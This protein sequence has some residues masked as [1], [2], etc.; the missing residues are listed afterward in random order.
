M[1]STKDDAN[2]TTVDAPLPGPAQASESEIVPRA[3]LEHGV[4]LAD[5]YRIVRLLGQGGMGSVYEAIDEARSGLRVAVKLLVVHQP[6]ALYRL[7]NEFRALAETVHPNLVGLHGLAA[8]ARGWFLVMDLVDA[9]SDFRSYVRSGENGSLDEPRLRSALVQLVRGVAAI[10]AARKLHRDLKPSNVL[11]THDGR[12]VIAD[13]GLVGDQDPEA[14]GRSWEGWFAGTPAYAAPEQVQGVAVGPAADVY[15]VGVLLFEALTGRLPIEGASIEQLCQR[16]LH[17]AAPD[18]RSLAAG[19]PADLCTLCTALLQRDPALRPDAR[20]LLV[21]LDQPPPTAVFTSLPFVG[22]ERELALLRQAVSQVRDRSPALA[23]VSGASGIGKTALVA[24]FL[25]LMRREPGTVVFSGRCHA[26]EQV[27]YNAFDRLVDVLGLYLSALSPVEAA[28][29]MPRDVALLARLF[30]TLARVPA[31]LSM[32]SG[33][34]RELDEAFLRTR[35]FAALK[36]LL[37]RIADRNLLIMCFDDLQWC[38]DDSAELLRELLRGLEAPACLFVCASRASEPNESGVVAMVRANSAWSCVELRLEPLGAA[39]STEL[40]RAMLG[41]GHASDTD[42]KLVIEE[43]AGS[44]F[45]IK[46]LA[47]S[48]R[49]RGHVSNLQET[50]AARSAKLD[51]ATRG[52]FELVCVA[53]QP[54]ELVVAMRAARL[55]PQALPSVLASSLLKS[56]VRSGREHLESSH[57]RIGETAIEAIDPARRA[58]LHA[59]LAQELST[60]SQADPERIARHYRAAG[61]QERAGPY[62]IRAAERARDGLAFGR[63]AELYEVALA[64][65]GDAERSALELA[66][67]DVYA[68][69]GKLAEAAQH[70]E[71]VLQHCSDPERRRG[72]AAKAML[73][74]L[75]AG[76]TERGARLADELCRELGVM[77]PP[78]RPLL[79]TLVQIWLVLRYLLGPRITSLPVPSESKHDPVARARLELCLRAT[80]GFVHASPDHSTYFGLQMLI[81]ARRYR[82]PRSW[83]QVM[84][85]EVTMRSVYR[86]AQDARDRQTMQRA[87][88][89]AEAQGDAEALAL[90][91]TAKGGGD[92]YTCQLQSALQAFERAEE[93]LATCGPPAIQDFSGARNGRLCT[94]IF[95]GQFRELLR[96]FDTWIAETHALGDFYGALIARLI[97]SHRF[98]ALDDPG[99]A[100]HA[101][102]DLDSPVARNTLL[103]AEPAWR[104]YVAL[105][106]ADPAAAFVEIERVRHARYF[107]LGQRI[108]AYRASRSLLLAR[109]SLM[110]AR[111]DKHGM[112]VRTAHREARKLE[113]EAF[114]AG[115]AG[116]AQTRAALAML[117]GDDT[118]ALAELTRAAERYDRCGVLLQA[119]AAR[120]Q[121]G[122]LR[123]GDEGATLVLAAKSAALALG[124]QNPERWFRMLV[125]GFPD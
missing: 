61:L 70:Y 23:L 103:C 11:V 56:S 120:Y 69:L 13:F 59:K 80:R 115:P 64:E 33:S 112:H 97:G 52:L 39:A 40:A 93:V 10:H 38:D 71:R 63:A 2:R 83:P 121:I 45:L 16:K 108:S 125:P 18:P 104:G 44:P 68:K 102:V 77:P 21:Q 98:L 47:S 27:P 67:A 3:S 123:G 37:A 117:R 60:D 74:H 100:R 50:I 5:R 66:L 99:A 20:Q 4:R 28:S 78:R 114:A 6:Q 95:A 34:I 75:L 8:D 41:G 116:A 86:G 35:A 14:A 46:E 36:E 7:K 30:P 109:A 110:A 113:R 48:A 1:G 65:A 9:S 73:L 42:L 90:V 119:E 106:E 76:Y 89:L 15:A 25:E 29:L 43:S 94:W 84:A 31:V 111:Q 105:Y 62:T 17:E 82:D 87:I 85:G 72:L 57:D 24:R 54:L 26:Q 53:G 92:L 96:H 79:A 55:E 49:L 122:L 51:A 88:A 124:V 32:P 22:R 101:L 81:E 19:A 12:V 91:L 118:E 107:R 58:E